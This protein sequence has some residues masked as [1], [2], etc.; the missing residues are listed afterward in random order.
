MAGLRELATALQAGQT[1]ASELVEKALEQ[2]QK[3]QSVFTA[4]NPGLI[5][6]ATSIDRARQK[7]ERITPLAGIPIALKD[8]FN[9]RNEKTLAGSIVR[10]HYAQPEDVRRTVVTRFHDI[11]NGVNDTDNEG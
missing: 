9:I 3:S 1:S 2:A 10:R 8:L 5:S 11:H 7:S 6:L 4:I